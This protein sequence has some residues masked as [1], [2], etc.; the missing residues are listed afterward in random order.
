LKVTG[1][2]HPLTAE[3]VQDEKAQ[4]AWR[5]LQAVLLEKRDNDR[6]DFSSE[7]SS[8]RA[9]STANRDITADTIPV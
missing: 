6:D 1:T 8:S 3:V 9:S 7:K 5:R 4:E 2:V